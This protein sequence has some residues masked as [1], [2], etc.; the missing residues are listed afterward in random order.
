MK[1]LSHIFI[2]L[3]IFMGNGYSKILNIEDNI[4]LEVPSNFNFINVNDISNSKNILG[5]DFMEVLEEYNFSF[6]I[7]GSDG[8]INFFK[9]YLSGKDMEEELWIKDLVNKFEKKASRSSSRKAVIQYAKKEIRKTFIDEGL[10][11]WTLILISNKKFQDY[12]LEKTFNIS[13]KELFDE[14]ENYGI[15]SNFANLDKNGLKIVQ[16]EINNYIKKNSNHTIAEALNYKLSPVVIS[17]DNKSNIYL[18]GKTKIRAFV[19]SDILLNYKGKYYLT[20][21]DNRFLTIYQECVF[22]CANFTKNFEKIIMPLQET[23]LKKIKKNENIVDDLE[24]L[25]NLYKSGALT[26]EEFEKAK[27]KILN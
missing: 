21:R 10:T 20:L 5:T 18:S 3:L 22:K 23:N 27:K 17:R 16:D 24:K 26:K 13:K 14:L 6:Y 19:G 25:N 4:S 8:V 2:L 7:L 15:P 1:K 11:D 12:D 9:R